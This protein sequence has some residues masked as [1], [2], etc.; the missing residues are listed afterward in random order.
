M[1]YRIEKRLSELNMTQ[2]DL[3]SKMGI[4]WQEVSWYMSRYA[5]DFTPALIESF[6]NVLET[7]PN[8]LLGLPDDSDKQTLYSYIESLNYK[9]F[10]HTY[11]SLT[12]DQKQKVRSLA[13]TLFYAPRAR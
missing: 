1:K 9:G 10:V 12:A 8:R 4:S 3:A 11:E 6:A 2:E 5:S 13:Q 7:T